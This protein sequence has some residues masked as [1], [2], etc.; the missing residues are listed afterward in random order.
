MATNRGFSCSEF[1]PTI[2]VIRIPRVT[3]ECPVICVA[4]PLPVLHFCGFFSVSHNVTVS[5]LCQPVGIVLSNF[6][7]ATSVSGL[8]IF[9][10]VG[11]FQIIILL[12][13]SDFEYSS[14][15]YNLK[16]KS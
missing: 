5:L 16:G 4:L 7:L 6:W 3:T 15:S 11:L 13:I 9:N 14:L 1:L 10:L 12:T 2:G 8:F